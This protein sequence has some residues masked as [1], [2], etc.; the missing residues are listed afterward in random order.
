MDG[1]LSL[2]G[3]VRKEWNE[4]GKF[5]IVLL[6]FLLKILFIKYYYYLEKW[7]IICSIR[8]QN[9]EF[10]KI[11]QLTFKVNFFFETFMIV[12]SKFASNSFLY[13]FFGKQKASDPT[14]ASQ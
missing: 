4:A 9:L 12:A 1:Y 13:I 8:V 11:F 2:Q 3:Q 6:Q 10:E 5:V 7:S 14:P